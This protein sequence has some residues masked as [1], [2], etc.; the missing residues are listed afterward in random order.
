MQ[1]LF[2]DIEENT[3][4]VFSNDCANNFNFEEFMKK[5][6][7]QEE[8]RFYSY[9]IFDYP[10]ETIGEESQQV[11]VPKVH[12]DELSLVKRA[13]L[14]PLEEIQESTPLKRVKVE[15]MTEIADDKFDLDKKP[16]S[17]TAL[18]FQNSVTGDTKE[19]DV[20][21]K[22]EKFITEID[23]TIKTILELNH[24]KKQP[25]DDILTLLIAKLFST[26]YINSSDYAT[27]NHSNDHLSKLLTTYL[28]MPV[29]IDYLEN[30][31]QKI[32]GG[33]DSGFLGKVRPLSDSLTELI[34][35]PTMFNPST[36]GSARP[37]K[38][39]SSIFC[40]C[41][42]TFLQQI[43]VMDAMFSYE[44]RNDGIKGLISLDNLKYVGEIIKCT[45]NLIAYERFK[46]RS[47]PAKKPDR[48]E[49][50]QS[51]E[52]DSKS[53]TINLRFQEQHAARR[54]TTW[55]PW[56]PLIRPQEGR[57]SI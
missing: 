33:H 38:S 28:P 26:S 4:H 27:S 6:A 36:F 43:R 57:N 16:M 37:G 29:M 22:L 7:I 35:S 45:L 55:Q 24:P 15:G 46:G 3:F 9:S 41:I 44:E 31:K 49:L 10:F 50:R 40:Y 13:K 25:D 51:F 30:R 19:G 23:G 12:P 14:E 42:Q 21:F 56:K 32:F 17:R 54:R 5:N 1:L 47:R 52:R 20:K 34:M 53:L 2:S 48:L 18:F 8:A 11:T 39:P